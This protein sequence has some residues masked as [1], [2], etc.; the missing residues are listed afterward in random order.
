MK[1]NSIRFE[2][3]FIYTLILGGVLA[4]VIIVLN[5]ILFYSAY[6]DL[7][8]GLRLKAQ[9]ISSSI[10]TYVEMH[11]EDPHALTSAAETILND[12]HRKLKWGWA[13]GFNRRWKKQVDKIDVNQEYVNFMAADHE[14][15]VSTKNVSGELLSI[16]SQH[17]K[18]TNTHE[19][20]YQNI[21]YQGQRLRVIN[22][23]F[24]YNNHGTSLLQIAIS[25]EPIVQLLQYWLYSL[26]LC[27]P[28]ILLLATYLGWRMASRF[29]VPVEKIIKTAQKITREDLSA[30]VKEEDYA[31]E[32]K[33]LVEAFNNTISRL[34]TSFKHIEEFSSNVAHELKTPLTIIRGETELALMRDY[35]P[36]E[37]KEV[38]RT[39]TQESERMLLTIEDLLY[40]ARVDYQPR[41]GKFEDFEFVEFFTEV[42]EQTRLLADPKKIKVNHF[43]P[44][45]SIPINADRLH[46]RRL[47]FNLI[48][49]ALKFTPAG[50][51]L[52]LAVKRVENNVLIMIT[53]TGRGISEKNLLK[54]FDKFFREENVTYGTGLGLSIV[55]AIA[56]AHRGH[57]AVNSVINQGT[58]FT[59][60]IPL[61]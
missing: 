48:D 22:Y 29:L 39:I 56:K 13:I 47:F 15:V 55:K 49:N 43:L 51:H 40:L 12:E 60:T 10:R 53:D 8:S 35:E 61:S 58:T 42:C 19:P 11:K 44:K 17:E 23:P 54:V 24:T 20:W 31:I 3:S 6:H 57:I 7:D 46:L 28:L 37:Y 52:D 50:G 26:I 21:T 18:R 25:P 16:L 38:L 36:E 1:F 5:I 4:A 32:M 30:R 45:N 27:I 9:E 41:F 2:T 34:E 33:S 14:A 59:I